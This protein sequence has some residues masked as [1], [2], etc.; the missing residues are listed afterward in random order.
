MV[1]TT[2]EHPFYVLA[3]APL[4]LS[5]AEGW[6]A[7]GET[8]GRWVPAGELAI[9]DAIRQADGTTGTVQAVEVVA[10]PQ[11]MYNLTVAQAHTFFVGDGQWLVHN[12][13]LTP[14]QMNR[15]I[16]RG[17]APRGIERVDT[18][19]IPGEQLHV[20]FSDDSALNIDGTWKHGQTTL[21]S[22]QREWLTDNGWTLPK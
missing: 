1:E 13:C 12:A 5:F 7:V 11:V 4:A 17:Q 19:K 16:Q 10:Q 6:L 15:A 3:S 22:P 9:G 2:P 21:T 20:H 18:P 14:N 8:V